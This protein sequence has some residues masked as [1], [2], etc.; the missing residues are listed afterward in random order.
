LIDFLVGALLA[1]PPPLVLLLLLLQAANRSTPAIARAPSFVLRD[2]RKTASLQAFFSS[3]A[4]AD[5]P[6]ASG[7]IA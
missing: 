1:P 6:C 2:A 7:V 5:E 4:R 3:V